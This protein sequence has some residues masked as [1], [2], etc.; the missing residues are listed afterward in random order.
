[1]ETEVPYVWDWIARHCHEQEWH[2][3][4][5]VAEFLATQDKEMWGDRVRAHW[6]EKYM[7]CDVAMYTTCCA[8]DLLVAVSRYRDFKN[9]CISSGYRCEDCA[10][11]KK[12]G[13]CNQRGSTSHFWLYVLE[14]DSGLKVDEELQ[15]ALKGSIDRI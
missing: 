1:M 2:S 3:A 4:A 12:H 14:I 15:E 11:A 13:F 7:F 5:N 10:M 8:F 9:G 6:K